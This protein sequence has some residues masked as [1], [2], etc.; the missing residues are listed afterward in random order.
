MEASVHSANCCILRHHGPLLAPAAA[1]SIS[2]N[3]EYRAS[4]YQV[5]GSDTY[6]GLVLEF[7]SG[8]LRST[9]TIGGI[10]GITSTVYA[11][12]NNDYATLITTTFTAGVTG[13]Y[14][15]QVGADWGR[16]GGVQAVHVGSGTA[17]DSF[18]TT[19][20]ICWGNS[21]SNPDVF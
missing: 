14:E 8:S 20:D 10:D 13:I 21:W 12:I 5:V 15:F 17:L 11:G 9:Q 4:T 7:Q 19:D 18:V 6:N 3:L 2:F 16:G 1:H